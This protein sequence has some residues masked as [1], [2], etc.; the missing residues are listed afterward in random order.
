MDTNLPFAAIGE[1]FYHRILDV[2]ETARIDFLVGGAFALRAYT[3]IER[4]TKDFDL[5]LR[6]PDVDAALTACRNAGLR[7]GHTFSHWIAKVHLGE[8]FIDLIYRAGNGLCEV[9]DDWFAASREADV[10]G[11][12]LRLCPPEEIIW[13]KAFIMERERFDGADVLHLL[14][15]CARSMDWPRLLGR[16]ADNWRVLLSHLILFGYVY[17]DERELIPARVLDDLLARL[18]EEIS[19]PR[20]RPRNERP[21]CRGTLLSREQYLPD[22]EQWGYDD[23]RIVGPSQMTPQEIIAWTNAI[24]DRPRS[25]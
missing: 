15:G 19:G 21:L 7:A 23:A 3:G 10:L 17:P 1:N 5:M 2:L 24:D 16:F 9:D 22:V 4:D 25:R 6:P 12:K 20:E 14:R 11:R 18:A 13:Q 8:H